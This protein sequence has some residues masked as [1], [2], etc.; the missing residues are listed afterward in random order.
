MAQQGVQLWLAPT[1]GLEVVHGTAAATHL[2]NAVQVL[3][4]GLGAVAAICSLRF[5][6]RG[7]GI[8]AEHF[9]P[10]V[11]VVARSVA[12]CKDVAEGIGR[13][14]VIGRGQHRHFVAHLLEQRH[15]VAIL[16][17]AGVQ[18]HVK[19]RKLN[20]AQRAHACQELQEVFVEEAEEVLETLNEFYPK[21][22]ANQDD[23]AALTEVRR[24][25]HTLKGSGRMVRALVAGELAWS[26]ENMLNRVIDGSVA[27]SQPLLQV[28]ADVITLFPELVEEYAKV[29]RELVL[30]AIENGKHVVTANE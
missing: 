9:G 7:V 3:L 13:A 29:A 14:V 17:S 23:Q 27:V 22:R 6:K 8:S 28:I 1:E 18:Q 30:K 19:Q 24:A 11:A 16:G 25:F 26:I 10:L 2:Q 20:L 12:T 5:F 21:W 4:A 15:V